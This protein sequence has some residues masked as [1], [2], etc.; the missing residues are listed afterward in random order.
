MVCMVVEEL[1]KG[2]FDNKVFQE[3]VDK[4][5]RRGSSSQLEGSE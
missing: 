1:K 3:R 2:K 5:C 4:F